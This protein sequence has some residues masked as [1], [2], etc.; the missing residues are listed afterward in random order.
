MSAARRV[1]HLI[2]WPW[3]LLG[4]AGYFG[5]LLV[6]SNLTVIRDIATPGSD[7]QAGIVELPLRCRTDLEITLLANLISLTPGT[8][9]LAVR[10]GPEHP[11]LYVHG[12]Y[13]PEPGAFR[14]E[15][16]DLEARMLRALRRN[17]NVGALPG[18]SA[19]D[20]GEQS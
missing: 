6:V 17:A 3:R 13:A 9:T 2:T 20:K 15:L 19:S 7:V 16:G 5:W 18:R 11:V 12:M 10:A 1:T 8:L 14:R 4:F